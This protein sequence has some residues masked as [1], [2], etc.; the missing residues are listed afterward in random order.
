MTKYAGKWALP[1]NSAEYRFWT[2]VEFAIGCWLWTGRISS[3]GYGNFAESHDAPVMVHRWAWEYFNGP[4]PLGMTID[5][6]KARGCISKLC[7]RPEHL[8]AVTQLENNLRWTR[9]I[10]HCPSN[11]PYD[12]ANTRLYRGHRYCRACAYARTHEAIP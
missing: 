1:Q 8:E 9:T 3:N 6:V 4:I 11:H 12:E 5:H 10:T 2:K 7:V